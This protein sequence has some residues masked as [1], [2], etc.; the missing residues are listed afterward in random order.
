MIDNSLYKTS[1]N[2]AMALCSSR[3]YCCE[4]ILTKLKNWGLG[5]A[6]SERVLDILRREK[7]IDEERYSAAFTRD[8]FRYNKWGKIKIAASLRQR[9]I[10]ENLIRTSLELID[11]EEYAK[12]IKQL[13][14]AQKRKV[15]AKSPYELRAK[16]MRYG[17]SKGFESSILY[18]ILGEEF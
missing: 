9:K 15:K 10:P 4:D 8:K 6:E 1:L 14:E 11:N 12:T 18:E 13:V 3:E 2:K 16:L 7:F 5:N 17:L